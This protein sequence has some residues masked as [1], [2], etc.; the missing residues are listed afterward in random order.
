MKKLGKIVTIILAVVLCFCTPSIPV[1]VNTALRLTTAADN[2]SNSQFMAPTQNSSL[3]DEEDLD[4]YDLADWTKPSNNNL[5]AQQ[6]TLETNGDFHDTYPYATLSN[7]ELSGHNPYVI[8]ATNT[9][10]IKNMPINGC[11]TTNEIT[12]PAN[13]YYRIQVSYRLKEQ[14]NNTTSTSAFGT[15]YLDDYAIALTGSN[16]GWQTATFY[17]N[18][19]IL[20]S[21]TVKPELYFGGR[22]RD[23]IGAIYFDN[24]MVTAIREDIFNTETTTNVNNPLCC[25]IHD[26]SK[27]NVDYTA[28]SGNFA[29]TQFN[30]GINS[31]DAR[32]YNAITASEVAARFNLDYFHTKDGD[33]N[34]MM[35]MQALN[36]NTALTLEGF[37]LQP[38]TRE[39]YMFQFYSI[40]T[41]AA[42]FSGFYLSITPADENATQNK[43]LQKIT[44]ISDYPY[45]NGWQLNTVFLFAGQGLNQ[46][47]NF[48]FCLANA[49]DN[50]KATGWVCIDDFKVYRVSGSYANK[51][52]AATCV[53]GTIDLNAS[54]NT[55]EIANGNFETGTSN[56][57]L[58][59]TY[60]LITND[61]KTKSANSGIVNLGSWNGSFGTRPGDL[62]GENNNVYMLHNTNSSRR[63]FVNSPAL[64]FTAD[65]TSYISFDACSTAATNTKAWIVTGPT[66]DEGY[67]VDSKIIYLGNPINIDGNG[68]QHYEFSVTEDTYAVSR[69]YYLRFEM[70]SQGY[71]YI[72]NVRAKHFGAADRT[73]TINL[74]N[75]LTISPKIWQSTDEAVTPYVDC[76]ADGITVE[77]INRQKTVVENNFA[78]NLSANSYY[79]FVIEARGE[80]AYLGMK[81]FAGLL[82]VTT[83]QI[84]AEMTYAYKLYLHI[85]NETQVNFQITLGYVADDDDE[86]TNQ[87]AE[88]RIFISS[89]QVNSINEDEYNDAETMA[90][91]DSRM[92]MLSPADATEEDEEETVT[93]PEDDNFFGKNWWFLIPTLITAISLLL[94]IITFLLRKIKFE[95]HITKKHT[96]YAR[97]MRLKNQQKKIV[98]QKSAKVDNITDDT[99]NN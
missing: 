47:Y 80:N 39:I 22:N 92:L 34:S 24:F 67:L 63:I 53:H 64:T 35:L 18:T 1:A 29:N 89:I 86:D 76:S 26:F 60:P 54:D 78:Y 87:I 40:A 82:K 72:D 14:D 71:A 90:N 15:F 91:D 88:G 59:N 10:K 32:S 48:G 38:A 3:F 41:A 77:N 56:N 84:N 69:S 20:E 27:V 43:K 95:R 51:N 62:G 98:A 8:V 61:W 9:N 79:E 7:A 11:Y 94:A 13:G 5:I 2:V 28:V 99:Q 66:D 49:D 70:D 31:S 12:L 97:D 93:E 73:S 42:D 30:T 68:W 23:A 36:S 33:N 17:L 21:A 81:D 57:G 25:I 19:D 74:S 4:T 44:T 75:A 50:A 65:K 85:E 16:A 6:V 58:N 52:A 45:H 55:P 37:T 46:A 96:S 83:D